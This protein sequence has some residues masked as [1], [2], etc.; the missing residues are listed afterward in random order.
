MTII[1]FPT[2]EK[3]GEAQAYGGRRKLCGITP[4]SAMALIRPAFIAGSIGYFENLGT[5]SYVIF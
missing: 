3:F 2:Y 4:L 5:V 1:G